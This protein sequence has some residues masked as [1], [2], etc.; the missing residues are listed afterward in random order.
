MWSS[1]PSSWIIAASAIDLALVT[2]LALSGTLMK[3]LPLPIVA[4][5]FAG[6]IGFALFLD[7][8][9]PPVVS[10]FKLEMLPLMR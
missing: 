4:A 1:R 2:A 5:V 10:V 3:A 6:A 9:K 7:Q 8:I